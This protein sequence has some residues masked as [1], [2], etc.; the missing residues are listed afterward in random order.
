MHPNL[1]EIRKNRG[2]EAHGWGNTRNERKRRKAAIRGLEPCDLR[3]VVA[4]D[5]KIRDA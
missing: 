3:M 2:D 1:E 5:G 4:D